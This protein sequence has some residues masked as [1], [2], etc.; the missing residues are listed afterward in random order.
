MVCCRELSLI[1]SPPLRRVMVGRS[2]ARRLLSA[3]ISFFGF[4]FASSS[5]LNAVF[6]FKNGIK[7]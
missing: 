7:V 1:Q 6:G 5:G 3:V 4:S 2:K